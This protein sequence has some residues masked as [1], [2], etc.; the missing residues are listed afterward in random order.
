M[1]IVALP[2]CNLRLKAEKPRSKPYPQ[3]VLSIGDAIRARRLDLGLHQKDAA[4]KTR[5]FLQSMTN[6][7]KVPNFVPLISLSPDVIG[8]PEA[9]IRSG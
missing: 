3:K 5:C 6:W 8:G 4:K 2:F 9:T 1:R 7:E